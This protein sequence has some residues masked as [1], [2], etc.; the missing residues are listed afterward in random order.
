MCSLL[1]TPARQKTATALPATAGGRRC[2]LRRRG[3]PQAAPF[4]AVAAPRKDLASTFNWPPTKTR[5]HQELES[6]SRRV[7]HKTSVPPLFCCLFPATPKIR[8][9]RPAVVP[10][11]G[12]KMRTRSIQPRFCYHANNTWQRHRHLLAAKKLLQT[13]PITIH[14]V[15]AGALISTFI[16]QRFTSIP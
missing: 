15:L 9:S 12:V 4:R 8:N 10:A 11:L 14:T 1:H 3:T 5:K 2:R 7:L 16:L 13:S 6:T